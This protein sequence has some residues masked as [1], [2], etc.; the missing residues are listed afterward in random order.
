VVIDDGKTDAATA[1]DAE[2]AAGLPAIPGPLERKPVS[3]ANLEL[4]E[5]PALI[6]ALERNATKLEGMKGLPPVADVVA[7]VHTGVALRAAYPR[8]AISFGRVRQACIEN[9]RAI[10]AVLTALA[11]LADR[12]DAKSDLGRALPPFAKRRK[13]ALGVPKR[14]ATRTRNKKKQQPTSAG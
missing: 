3:F 8:L 7:L 13:K 1:Q 9:G 10:G 14:A 5:E 11:G 6:A 2:L 4:L 12:F